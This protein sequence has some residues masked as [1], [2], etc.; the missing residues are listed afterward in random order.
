[1]SDNNL[2][3]RCFRVLS[4]VIQYGGGAGADYAVRA[5][6]ILLARAISHGISRR[7]VVLSRYR[8]SLFMKD[9]H[10]PICLWEDH[11]NSASMHMHYN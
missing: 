1:M 11:L 2:I 7:C 8:N 6:G 3:T 10:L 5:P 9:C 4:Q